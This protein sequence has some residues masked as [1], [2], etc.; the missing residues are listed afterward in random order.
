MINSSTFISKVAPIL[1]EQDIFIKK[2]IFETFEDSKEIKIIIEG[3]RRMRKCPY[4]L[5]GYCLAFNKKCS[6]VESCNNKEQVKDAR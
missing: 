1:E 3:T 2:I 6:E 5:S 4:D